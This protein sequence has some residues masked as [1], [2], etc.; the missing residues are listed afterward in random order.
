MNE[1][2]RAS[3]KSMSIAVHLAARRRQDNGKTKISP[4]TDGKTVLAVCAYKKYTYNTFYIFLLKSPPQAPIF[5]IL[6]PSPTEAKGSISLL[7][8]A[9]HGQAKSI[10]QDSLARPS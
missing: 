9:K 4:F 7:S 5:F 2:A 3:K 1:N 6:A 10:D 8:Q